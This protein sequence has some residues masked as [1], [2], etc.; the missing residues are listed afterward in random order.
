MNERLKRTF[1]ICA[2]VALVLV[3]VA[4]IVANWLPIV[5]GAQPAAKQ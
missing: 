5:I 1:L 3:I 4:L 2:E